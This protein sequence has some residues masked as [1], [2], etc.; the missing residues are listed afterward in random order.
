[1]IV[2]RQQ[3]EICRIVWNPDCI[4]RFKSVHICNDECILNFDALKL[5]QK[6]EN[7]K[8]WFLLTPAAPCGPG[9]PADNKH[10]LIALLLWRGPLSSL[11]HRE[12][13]SSKRSALS[14]RNFLLA[15]RL[16]SVIP[17]YAPRLDDS[18]MVCPFLF[19]DMP[20]YHP[21]VADGN[22]KGHC[23]LSG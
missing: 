16:A 9:W 1:M 19:E 7:S 4:K 10:S 11:F 17:L 8:A 20:L 15:F 12:R 6:R 13:S 5:C 3:T 14:S 23:I 21:A 22:K 18:F 2:I